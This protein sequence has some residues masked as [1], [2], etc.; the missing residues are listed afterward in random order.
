[1]LLPVL[2]RSWRGRLFPQRHVLY[3]VYITLDE[4]IAAVRELALV[5]QSLL[6]HAF[7]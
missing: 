7:G 6:I 3:S 5:A 2:F 4:V 1:M